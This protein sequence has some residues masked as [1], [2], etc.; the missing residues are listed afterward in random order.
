VTDHI[1]TLHE[2]DREFKQ[3]ADESGITEFRRT[4]GLNDHPQFIQALAELVLGEKA[5]WN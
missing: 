2:I 4:R 1:E 3:I 5:F